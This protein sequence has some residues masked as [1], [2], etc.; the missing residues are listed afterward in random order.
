MAWHHRGWDYVRIMQSC[1]NM[2][3]TRGPERGVAYDLWWRV[4]HEQGTR[5]WTDEELRA[6]TGVARTTVDRLRGGKRPPTARV[7]NA[8][9]DALDIDLTEAHRLAGRAPAPPAASIDGEGAPR[10]SAREAI[11]RDPAYT[12]QQR[13]AIMELLDIFE[14][15]NRSR[16]P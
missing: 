12:D 3:V 10:V 11:L 14:Q 4:R 8:L 5:G 7:V 2:H 15:A 6:R 9:A 16:R 1:Y 13:R